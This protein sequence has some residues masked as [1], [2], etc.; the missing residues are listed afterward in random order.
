MTATI[1]GAA[2]PLTRT[3]LAVYP[4]AAAQLALEELL[5][6][7]APLAG[8]L[9]LSL[10]EQLHVTLRFFG[11]LNRQ[12][13]SRV[14]SV[15]ARAAPREEPLAFTLDGLG[16]FPNWDRPHVIWVG[17]GLGATALDWLAARLDT[18][19]HSAG[20][21]SADVP[22]HAHLTVARVRSGAR[23]PRDVIRKLST[24]QFWAGP[25]RVSELY[26]MASRLRTGH[27]KHQVLRTFGLG[28]ARS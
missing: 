9:R 24:K 7:F 28:A 13:V 27:A 16:A 3:F 5:A 18:E 6:E 19:F 26:L 1:P 25:V 23:L 4:D 8:D 17:V 2:G 15:L 11:D 10:P 22:F 20:L 14:E 21:G 12:A